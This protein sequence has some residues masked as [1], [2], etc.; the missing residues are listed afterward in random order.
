[1]EIT[2]SIE[3]LKKYNDQLVDTIGSLVE[4]RNMDGKG[5]VKRIKTFTY[6]LANEV[7]K[8]FPEYGLDAH[9]VAV[10]ASASALHDMGKITIPDS[11]LFKPARL[12][13]E[14]FDEMKTHTTKGSDMLE[15]MRAAWN[16]EFHQA[17][18]DICR[19]HHEK[20]DGNG[21]PDGLKGEEIPI[22]A[23]IVSIADIYDAL[24]CVRADR[25]A[26]Q[27]MQAVKMIITGECGVF[28]PKLME[29]FKN[30]TDQFEMIANKSREAF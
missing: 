6:I 18:H 8:N 29:C 12:T 13:R 1:M 23:Q 22:A 28:N 7:M 25:S 21:Y 20:Y 16:D 17:A 9:K 2:E 14:E 5:H 11:I 4:T 15:T 19:H 10:I 3:E 27:P 30:C 26:F 24:V